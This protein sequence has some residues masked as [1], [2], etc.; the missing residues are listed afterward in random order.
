[1]FLPALAWKNLSRYRKRTVITAMAL[2]FGLSTYIFLDGWLKGAETE[3]ERNLVSYETGAARI[4]TEAYWQDRHRLPL[5][6]SI[7]DPAA[8]LSILAERGV[9][10]TPRTVFGGEAVVAEGSMPIRV[11]AVDPATDDR[12]FAFRGTITDGRYL[13][14]GENGALVGAWLA[15]DLGLAVGD[16]VTVSTRTRS[17]YRQTLDLEVVGILTCPNPAINKGNLF[18]PLDTAD[19]LME[20]EGTV[21]EI[22]LRYADYRR[23]EQENLRLAAALGA[24]PGLRV[25]GWKDLSADYL[26]ISSAKK[27]GSNVMLLFVFVIAAVGV[28]NTMLMTILERTREL[29]MMRALGM[30]DREIRRVFLL[31]AAGI[32]LIG[33]VVGV[34]VGA[35]ANAA[36]VRWGIDMS[37]FIDM[38]SMDIGYRVAAVLKSA[39]NPPAIVIAFVAGILACVAVAVFPVRRALKRGIT[40]CL[41]HT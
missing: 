15:Q 36:M 31:E 17:G 9:T 37:A 40:E 39:W 8:I 11:I 13:E 21:T 1:M 5:A 35:L 6:S 41:R 27:G 24:R 3:S 34:G 19:A 4:V 20:M 26:G 28:S 33:S 12:V 18:L 7:P 10:A 25:V 38:K 14:P 32:G 22:D 16:P 30:R 29:G 2:A 23:A